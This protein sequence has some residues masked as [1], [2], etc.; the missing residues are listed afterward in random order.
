[1]TNQSEKHDRQHMSGS[2]TSSNVKPT[3]VGQQQQ[4]D[5]KGESGQQQQSNQ[6]QG[7]HGNHGSEK[8]GQHS[9]SNK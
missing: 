5:K 4:G 8:T 2:D 7:Q 6:Q 9:G 1:M 3:N